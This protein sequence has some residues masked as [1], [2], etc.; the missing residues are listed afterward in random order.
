MLANVI[1]VG[2][3]LCKLEWMYCSPPDYCGMVPYPVS[4]SVMKIL[5][6]KPPKPR[7]TVPIDFYLLRE[8]T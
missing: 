4:S 6:K 3:P 8:I 1:P 5:L 7:K 2:F